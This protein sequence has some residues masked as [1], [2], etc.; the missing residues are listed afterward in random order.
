MR[1]TL[2]PPEPLF[3]A[4]AV[5][6]GYEWP[7][8]GLLEWPWSEFV[9]EPHHNTE[10][11]NEAAGRLG[12]EMFTGPD[13]WAV[14]RF[15]ETRCGHTHLVYGDLAPPQT[16]RLHAGGLAGPVLTG[17]EDGHELGPRSVFAKASGTRLTGRFASARQIG[18]DGDPQDI[19][20]FANSFGHLLMILDWEMNAPQMPGRWDMYEGI[21]GPMIR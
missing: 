17:A 13:V 7:E 11:F 9:P 16:F 6:G 19:I 15:Y 14:N 12:L 2:G 4:H 8:E 10:Q 3:P 20:P 1:E 21:N 5:P 18:T